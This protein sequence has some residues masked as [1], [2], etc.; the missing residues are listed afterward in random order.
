MLGAI[1]GDVIGSCYEW[2]PQKTKDFSL[3]TIESCLTDDSFMTLAVGCACSEA[4]LN[5]ET[6]FKRLAAAWMRKIGR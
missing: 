3:F 1:I 6:D 2:N 5:D 4:D